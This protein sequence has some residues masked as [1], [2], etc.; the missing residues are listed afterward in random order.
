MAV[1]AAAVWSVLQPFVVAGLTTYASAKVDQ[2]AV[3]QAEKEPKMD[4]VRDWKWERLSREERKARRQAGQAWWQKSAR[5]KR[6]AERR[7]RRQAGEAWWQ[8]AGDSDMLP[9]NLGS[10]LPGP[11]EPGARGSVEGQAAAAINPLVLVAVA[12]GALWF[13]TRKK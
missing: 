8:V 4:N 6:Q 11:G 2:Y 5:Q 1:T 10:K 7:A 12:G 9:P 13:L 3:K